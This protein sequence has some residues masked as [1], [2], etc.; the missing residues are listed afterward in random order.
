MTNYQNLYL[1]IREAM[2][3]QDFTI[4]IGP[5]FGGGFS[6]NAIIDPFLTD[7]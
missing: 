3:G 4:K 7:C 2:L 1:H 5:G 6:D